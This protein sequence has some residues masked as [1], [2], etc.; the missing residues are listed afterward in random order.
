V[1]TALKES[2]LPVLINSGLAL[3]MGQQMLYLVGL[4]D[5]WMGHPDLSKALEQRRGKTPTILLVHEPDFA[6]TFCADSTVSLQLS[7]HSHGG[8]IRIPGV[9]A[10]V[11]PPHGRKYDQGLYRVKDMW[12]YTTR[13]IG[14]IGP[15]VRLN[16]R[17]EI[18][19]ITL[20]RA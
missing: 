3:N 16:C 18:T 8:Q 17:P 9:G 14:V 10:L 15:P 6:D 19:E 13:G 2:G 7:G 1:L 5:G 20:V 4:D 11:L 12:V